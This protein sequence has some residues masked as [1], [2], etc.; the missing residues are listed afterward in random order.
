MYRLTRNHKM[1]RRAFH[2]MG[3]R[4]CR[5]Y[6]IPLETRYFTKNE[7]HVYFPHDGNSLYKEFPDSW[8][9]PIRHCV[10]G[11]FGVSNGLTGNDRKCVALAINGDLFVAKSE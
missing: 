5:L 4:N 3:N 8:L 11:S 6:G 7:L 1:A 9:F 2:R 10:D